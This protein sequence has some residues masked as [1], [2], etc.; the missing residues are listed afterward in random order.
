MSPSI[1]VIVPCHNQAQFLTEALE[2][3]LLQTYPNWECI[4]V[5]DGSKDNTEEVA[6]HYTSIDKRFQYLYSSNKG[7]SLA[8]NS[9]IDLAKGEFILP[10]DADDKISSNYLEL[11]LKA[12]DENPGLKLVYGEA[13][14]FGDLT[15]KWDLPSY[16]YFSLLHMNI[17]YCSAIFRKNDFKLVGKYSSEMVHGLEDWDLWLRLLKPGSKVLKLNE[18]VF[19]YRKKSISRTT[20]LT[21][22]GNEEATVRQ[23]ITRNKEIY[24]DFTYDFLKEI[25]HY[26]AEVYDLK[27]K[28]K[29]INSSRIHSIASKLIS[30]KNYF[31]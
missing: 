16:S 4:I 11:A 8:R 7:V 5:N 14:F 28:L 30:L 29:L 21:N 1:S 27:A 18:V 2:S 3:L 26:K 10:L 20:E 19:F 24:T 25:E 13:E 12:F 15:C 6:L 23:L 22:R 17:I 9:G 31:L